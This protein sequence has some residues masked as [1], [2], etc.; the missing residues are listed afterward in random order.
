MAD[1]YAEGGFFLG[2]GGREVPRS[3]ESEPSRLIRGSSTEKTS[4]PTIVY[5]VQL[6]AK[7]LEKCQQS[8][9]QR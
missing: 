2:G 7:G 6:P 5:L 8:L 3:S 4:E 9:T 1:K